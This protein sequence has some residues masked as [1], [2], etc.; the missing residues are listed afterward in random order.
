MELKHEFQVKNDRSGKK[1]LIIS[2]LQNF[3]LSHIKYPQ[4]YFSRGTP[5]SVYVKLN[6]KL[7][8]LVCAALKTLRRNIQS[9]V[10]WI[11]VMFFNARADSFAAVSI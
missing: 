11:P 6:S 2:K 5:N 1:R 9:L 8:K 4:N 3:K 10:E 7:Q